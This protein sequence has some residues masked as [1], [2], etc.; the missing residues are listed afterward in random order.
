MVLSIEEMRH[1]SNALKNTFLFYRQYVRPGSRSLAEMK[2][3]KKNKILSQYK[4]IGYG[5][6]SLVVAQQ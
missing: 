6:T 2:I 4:A 5:G 1:P 3:A